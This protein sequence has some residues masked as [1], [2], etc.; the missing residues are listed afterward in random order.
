[1]PV[2]NSSSNNTASLNSSNCDGIENNSNLNNT[3]NFDG[4]S[5]SPNVAPKTKTPLILEIVYSQITPI[6]NSSN[7]TIELVV[8]YYLIFFF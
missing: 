4:S 1:M 7:S 6:S 3:G 5:S 8:Y 2:T